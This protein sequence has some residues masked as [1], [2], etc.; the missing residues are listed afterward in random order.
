MLAGSA[1]CVVGAMAVVPRV[2]GYAPGGGGSGERSKM[3]LDVRVP[4]E[5]VPVSIGRT[6]GDHSA[7]NVLDAQVCFIYSI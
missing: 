5:T 1:L 4:G 3:F 6:I 7:G 2:K